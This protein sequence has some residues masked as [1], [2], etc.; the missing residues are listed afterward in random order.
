MA[1]EDEY[2]KFMYN[3]ENR[4]KCSKCP[5]NRHFDDWQDRY[6]CGQWNCW[7]DIHCRRAAKLSN[8]EES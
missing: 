8:K 5:V 7:V 3:K 4:F 2:K 6:P 1:Y